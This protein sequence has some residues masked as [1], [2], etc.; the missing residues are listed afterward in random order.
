MFL[1]QYRLSSIIL[2][3]LGGGLI[4]K[5]GDSHPVITRQTDRQTDT[6]TERTDTVTERR[7][8][9]VTHRE[10]MRQ[11]KTD[12]EKTVYRDRKRRFRY[13]WKV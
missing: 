2:E 13:F 10:R 3:G 6:V 11:G 1:E 12:D 7:T 9:A 8:D 5:D 4:S